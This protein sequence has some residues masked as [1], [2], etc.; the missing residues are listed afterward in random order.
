MLRQTM[1]HHLTIW[2]F[3][4]YPLCLHSPKVGMAPS[5]DSEN[6]APAFNDGSASEAGAVLGQGGLYV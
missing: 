4:L 2:V 1:D 3:A 5:S 6:E